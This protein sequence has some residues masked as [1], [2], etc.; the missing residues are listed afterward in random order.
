ME[1]RRLRVSDPRPYRHHLH[2]TVRRSVLHLS[3]AAPG[4]PEVGS[5]MVQ[6]RSEAGSGVGGFFH[7]K[8]DST[9][10]IEDSGVSFSKNEL[11]IN[12]GTIAQSDTKAFLVAMSAGGDIFG[13]FGVGFF[14]TYLVRTRFVSTAR[15]NE[16]EQYIW[17]SAAGVSITVQKDTEIV[18]GEVLRG[19]EDHFLLEVGPFQSSW[20]YDA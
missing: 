5:R 18:H 10:T 15:N 4:S 8:T 11:V 3:G 2:R 16:D 13:L 7:D 17:E 9:I 14:S 6:G 12:F 1:W 20:G 19:N